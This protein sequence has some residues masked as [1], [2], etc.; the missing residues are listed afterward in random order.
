M[1]AAHES[2]IARRGFDESAQLDLEVGNLVAVEI[3]PD[4]PRILNP[5]DPLMFVTSMTEG[6]PAM[7][8]STVEA[9]RASCRPSMSRRAKRRPHHDRHNRFETDQAR[10]GATAFAPAPRRIPQAHNGIVW[11]KRDTPS[12]RRSFGG[13]LLPTC[14]AATTLPNS[15]IRCSDASWYQSLDCRCEK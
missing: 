5:F 11:R 13:E 14:N 4:D 15:S 9:A 8:V 3:A 2:E 12:A 10:K 1:L 6:I 7:T